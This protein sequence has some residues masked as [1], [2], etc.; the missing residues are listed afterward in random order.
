MALLELI[1]RRDVRAFQE[2]RFGPIFLERGG[3]A[4]TEGEW[5]KSD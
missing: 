1:R 3:A 4:T 5:K 2:V